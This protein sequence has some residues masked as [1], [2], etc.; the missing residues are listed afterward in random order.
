MQNRLS[1]M[2]KPKTQKEL[3]LR[4]A[5]LSILKLKADDIIN[6]AKKCLSDDKFIKYKEMLKMDERSIIEALF[7][8]EDIDP[9]KYS[10]NVRTLL[11][12]LQRARWLVRSVEIDA[13][14][15]EKKESVVK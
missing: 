2:F 11:H 14:R 9:V 8:Y 13:K 1:E 6:N 4:E 15:G 7:K 12:D 10:F 5:E 3:E